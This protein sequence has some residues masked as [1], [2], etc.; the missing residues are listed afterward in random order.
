MQRLGWIL[1][2]IDSVDNERK[3]LLINTLQEYLLTQRLFYI[4]AASELETMGCTRNKRWMT[5]ENTT[6]E[7]DYDT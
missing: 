4:P 2:K 6:I 1:D 3:V 7:S 5:I